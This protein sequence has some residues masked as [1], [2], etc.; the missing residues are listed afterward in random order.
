MHCTNFS[1]I[2]QNNIISIYL[3]HWAIKICLNWFY[4]SV[5]YKDNGYKLIAEKKNWIDLKNCIHVALH[6]SFKAPK[7]KQ[8]ECIGHCRYIQ[9]Y[10]YFTKL[11]YL[12]KK[13]NTSHAEM[14]INESIKW[15]G[16]NVNF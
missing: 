16:R 8:N 6:L 3:L 13:G 12:K 10:I 9:V 7:K 1:T 11:K 5:L 15:F 2:K 14:K 4:N